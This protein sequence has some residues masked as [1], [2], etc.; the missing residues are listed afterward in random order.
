LGKT[1]QPLAILASDWL[2]LLKIL[3]QNYR[4]K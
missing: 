1:W 2:K 3:F 4:S